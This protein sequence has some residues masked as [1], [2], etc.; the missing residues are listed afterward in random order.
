[1][2]T[3]KEIPGYSEELR[4]TYDLTPDSIVLDAGGYR[5]D[6]AAAISDRYG[7]NVIVLEPIKE[8][9]RGIVNRFDGNRK[10]RVFNFA[11]GATS[12][13]AEF[14][15]QNDSTGGFADSENR[16]IVRIETVTDVL[17]QI[18][19]NVVD[20]MKINIE[21]GEWAVVPDLIKNGL[22]KRVVNLQ[23]QWHPVGPGN[24][25]LFDALQRGLSQTHHLT[26]DSGWVWQNWSLNK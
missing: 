12:G 4:L 6:W 20:L 26:F 18:K 15:V 25:Q 13:T 19:E 17:S 7:C 5:G 16:E 14:G 10:V 2:N 23:I 8:F 1:M 24:Q 9:Y 11:L 3:A 21:G 22:I